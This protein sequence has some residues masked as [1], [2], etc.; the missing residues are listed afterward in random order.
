MQARGIEPLISH[1]L[2]NHN[3]HGTLHETQSQ[4]PAC[5]SLRNGNLLTY[6]FKIALSH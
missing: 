1:I 4:S 5:S 3:N 6:L 2:F